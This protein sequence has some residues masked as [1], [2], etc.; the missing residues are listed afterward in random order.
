[1]KTRQKNAYEVNETD[2]FAAVKQ[3]LDFLKEIYFDRKPNEN[4]KAHDNS[5]KN[6]E[7][8]ITSGDR[9]NYAAYDFDKYIFRGLRRAADAGI[10]SGAA[11][12]LERTY[13]KD[14]TFIDYIN[15]HKALI[16]HAREKFP[17]EYSNKKDL[18]VLAEIQH[19][20]GA[21]CLVDFSYSFLTALWFACGSAEEANS[22]EHKDGLI[23]CVNLNNALVNDQIMSVIT[24]KDR[25]RDI[26][27]LLKDTRRFVDFDGKYRFRF[28]FWQPSKFNNRVANQDSLFVFGLEQF[29]LKK[30]GVIT[31]RIKNESKKGI[32]DVL[33]QFFNISITTIYPDINGYSEAHNK[34]KRIQTSSWEGNDCLSKGTFNMLYKNNTLALDYLDRFAC[35]LTDENKRLGC[36]NRTINCAATMFSKI[37][38]YYIKAEAYKHEKHPNRAILNYQM[39]RKEYVP[40]TIERYSKLYH[41]KRSRKLVER[42]QKRIYSTYIQELLLLYETKRFNEGIELCKAIIDNYS[43]TKYNINYAHVSI[44]ELNILYYHS[45]I[46]SDN[47][48]SKEEKEK[49]ADDCYNLCMKKIN[50]YFDKN[51]TDSFY[52]LLMKFFKYFVGIYF[53]KDEKCNIE[54]Y[55]AELY[56]I[57]K[58]ISNDSSDLICDWFFEDLIK[59]VKDKPEKQCSDLYYL[60]ARFNELQDTLKIKFLNSRAEQ[61]LCSSD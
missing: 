11:Y 31:I 14:Y 20:G 15:Y 12:R 60:L 49:A 16:D 2:G 26:E 29:D 59:I 28:W 17:G 13:G 56:R 9:N 33:E 46:Y 37:E 61:S 30:N 36:K 3:C 7:A 41:E 54:N 6:E 48:L 50:D 18:D 38:M 25:G 53:E 24:E 21:T 8:G 47:N 42:I 19:N 5:I 55:K 22:E 32:L 43:N 27:D 10:R 23:Y 51:K 52:K 39:A 4:N 1:M 58:S 40:E 35:C 45:H 57:A 44:I 34:F